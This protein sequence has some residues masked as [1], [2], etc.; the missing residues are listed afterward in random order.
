[1]CLFAG[2]WFTYSILFIVT[3]HDLTTWTTQTSY[4]PYNYGQYTDSEGYI[5]TVYDDY[6]LKTFNESLLTFSYRNSTINPITNR[7]YIELDIVMTSRYLNYPMVLKLLTIIP[8]LGTFITFSIFVWVY[9]RLPKP[10]KDDRY[11]GRLKKRKKDNFIHIIWKRLRKRMH[12]AM[13]AMGGSS[14]DSKSDP[15]RPEDLE[16]DVVKEIVVAAWRTTAAAS[17]SCKD[18]SVETRS[19]TTRLQ[20]HHS[21]S[22]TS[23]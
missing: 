7:T 2:K 15:D 17:R 20:Q 11:A 1:M 23:C 22:D 13:E 9:G 6:S 16:E 21:G 5:Y 12:M 18:V 8:C 19:K 3:L 10:T 14:L 4:A